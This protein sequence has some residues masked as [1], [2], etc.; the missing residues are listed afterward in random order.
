[1]PESLE[2]LGVLG[3]G[4]AVF[5]RHN[6]HLHGELQGL[7]S[8][9]FSQIHLQ[10]D[11]FSKQVVDFGRVIGATICV[12]TRPE[13]EIIFAQRPKRFGLTRFVLGRQ[14]E[15]CSTLVVILKLIEGG[16]YLLI[17]AFIGGLSEPEPWD[18]NA[19]EQSVAFWN[20]HALIWGYEET[21]PGTQNRHCPW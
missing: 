14:P 12:E 2:L 4:Q 18:R 8:E 5:N 10:G 21:I 17:T 19:T 3:S 13:D 20:S 15:P 6:S 11:Q 16:N 7:L 1:M 9:A